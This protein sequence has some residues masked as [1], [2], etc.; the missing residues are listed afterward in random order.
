MKAKM[1]VPLQM[2]SIAVVI[3]IFI[4]TSVLATISTSVTALAQVDKDNGASVFAPG[5]ETQSPGAKDFAPGQEAKLPGPQPPGSG[6]KDFTPGQEGLKS[7]IVG[8]N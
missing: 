8:P 6:S 3:A 1:N 7:G 4:T 5:K 2:N